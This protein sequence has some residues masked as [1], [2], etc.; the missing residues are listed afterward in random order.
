M[1]SNRVSDAFTIGG[2]W[3]T[4]TA[5]GVDVGESRA[6]FLLGTSFLLFAQKSQ[7]IADHFAGIAIFTGSHLIG[8]EQF[9][10]G[11]Q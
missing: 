3:L 7:G 1:L 8:D 6:Q 4:L 11:R 9:P 5:V 2:R 10:G